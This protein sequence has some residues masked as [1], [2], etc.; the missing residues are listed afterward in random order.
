MLG[1]NSSILICTGHGDNDTG[2][3]SNGLIER[4]IVV[5]IGKTCKNKLQKLGFTNVYL[6][7]V[8]TGRN[9]P[10]SYERSIAERYDLV[11]SIHVNAYNGQAQGFEVFC[12]LKNNET[13]KISQEILN[14]MTNYGFKSR[15]VKSGDHL[16]MVGKL[17]TSAILVETGFIDNSHDRELINTKEKQ[18]KIGELYAIAIAK[19]LGVEILQNNNQG[20]YRVICG[21]YKEK[22]NAER[23]KQLLESAGFSGIFLEYKEV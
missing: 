7:G 2:A 13:K 23:T 19:G 10:V 21:S 16:A 18:Q 9:G 15:G 3:V 11:I 14:S 17:K 12:N 1:K 5:P 22:S 20:F 8:D 6:E 4:D